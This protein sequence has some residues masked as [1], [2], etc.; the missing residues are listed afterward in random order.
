MSPHTPKTSKLVCRNLNQEHRE[1]RLLQLQPAVDYGDPLKCDL[2]IASLT[3]R[4]HFQ[5][6]SNAWGQW[7]VDVPL[8]TGNGQILITANLET[9]LRAIRKMDQ[10]ISIWVDAICINQ[11]NVKERNH[12]VQLMRQ[13][14]TNAMTVN[15]WLGEAFSG[16]EDSFQVLQTMQEVCHL[17]RYYPDLGRR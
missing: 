2:K 14:Y 3:S 7:K 12:Q 13:I 10:S 4:P 16:V 17:E 9:A 1:I 11:A 6:L 15:V 5:S 8:D